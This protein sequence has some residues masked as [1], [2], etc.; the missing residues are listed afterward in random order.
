[1]LNSTLCCFGYGLLRFELNNSTI[2]NY[3]LNESAGVEG[4]TTDYKTSKVVV[5]GKNADPLKVC[6]RVERKSGRKVELIS[7]L[8]KTPDENIKEEEIKKEEEPK[9]EKK[10][11]VINLITYY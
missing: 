9:E 2:C 7:P 1:M 11:E 6:E 8:K 3:L 10:D 5:K 4:V